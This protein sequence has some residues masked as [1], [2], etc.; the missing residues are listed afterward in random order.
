MG[1][2]TMNSLAELYVCLYAREFPAQALLRLRPELHDKPCVVMEGDP[3]L[4]VVSSLNTKARLKGLQA[5]MTRVEVETVAGPVVLRRSL[6]AEA[7]TKAALFE[8]AGAF[9]PHVEDRSEVSAFVCCID[10]AGTQNLFGPPEMLARHLRQRVRALGISAR[11]AMSSNLHAAVCLAKGLMGSSLRVVQQGDEATALASLPLSVLSLTETQSA[12]FALWGIHT[13]GMLAA[14]PEKELISRMGQEGKRLRQIAR[15]ELPHL[16]QAIEVPFTLKERADLDSPLENLESLL[17][18]LSVM[19]EQL[20]LRAQARIVML[21]SVTITLYLDGGGSHTRTVRPARPT[22]DKQLW[23]KLLHLDLEAHPP[24]AA[25]LTVEL[26]A[27]PGHSSTVQFGLF[28]PQLP[29][30]GRL[31]VTLARIAAMV[32]E[33]NVGQAVLD[34]THAPEGFHMEPFRVSREDASAE[35]QSKVCLR[36][37]R[38]PQQLAVVLEVARPASFFYRNQHCVVE[39]AYGPWLAS[40]E[41]WEQTIW[42]QEQWDLVARAADGGLLFCCMVRDLM[43]DQ[44]Q[45]VALYD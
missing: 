34:D 41:W 12:T 16:F 29:E 33:G 24:Q 13:L 7:A 32:G 9:S 31:D 19:L 39:R 40:G 20:I 35:L 6:E 30:P 8:C 21:A 38:P 5:G 45:L 25:I 17:F 10:I 23:L 44:W 3:P 42:G 37:I 15:G 27:E 2:T 11:V 14:L 26:H 22:N 43:Q 4:E 28:S 18:G 1:G 36:R